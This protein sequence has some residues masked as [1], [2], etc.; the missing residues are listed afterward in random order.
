[1]QLAAPRAKDSPMLMIT[2][3]QKEML[4]LI[5]LQIDEKTPSKI[6]LERLSELF[7]LAEYNQ[8][9]QYVGKLMAGETQMGELQIELVAFGSK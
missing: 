1:M 2:F 8:V 7:S 5:L 3:A 9:Q 6:E 4:K